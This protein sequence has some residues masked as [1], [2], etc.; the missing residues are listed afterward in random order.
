[1]RVRSF[2]R[3]LAM[4]AFVFEQSKLSNELSFSWAVRKRRI[5]NMHSSSTSDAAN[6][7]GALSA[8]SP[9]SREDIHAFKSRNCSAAT[10]VTKRMSNV[11]HCSLRFRRRAN[12]TRANDLLG[13]D[14][15]GI[16]L[17][18]VFCDEVSDI[19]MSLRGGLS[20]HTKYRRRVVLALP[21]FRHF[22]STHI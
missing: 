12:E 21:P 1:M 2:M 15:S 6:E 3:R 14:W 7:G 20:S 18:S 17:K 13:E 16:L 8:S 5:L 22:V 10:I 11:D 19:P 4:R 9:A